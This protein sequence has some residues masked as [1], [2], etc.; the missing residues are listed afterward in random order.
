MHKN[1]KLR[2]F[3][4]QMGT[5]NTPIQKIATWIIPTRQLQHRNF[6]SRITPTWTIT[7]RKLPTQ[8]NYHPEIPIQII[9]IQKIQPNIV[10]T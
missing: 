4:L 6:P 2:N 1:S 10:P 7:N 5:R 9:L 8:D 3:M